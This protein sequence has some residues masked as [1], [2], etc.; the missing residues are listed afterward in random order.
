MTYGSEYKPVD[1][2]L[3]NIEHPSKKAIISNAS[4]LHSAIWKNNIQPDNV[5]L[6]IF[7]SN[8]T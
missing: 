2:E 1:D 5:S 7:L 3:F 4:V 8:L 6:T